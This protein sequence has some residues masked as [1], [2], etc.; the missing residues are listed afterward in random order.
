MLELVIENTSIP[1]DDSASI[2]ITAI[3][4]ALSTDNTGKVYSL[5]FKLPWS[6]QLLNLLK[7]T[8]RF[9]AATKPQSLRAY[10]KVAGFFLTKGVMKSND[11][12]NKST[13]LS[14]D[15]HFKKDNNA[16]LSKLTDFKISEVCPKI[17]IPQTVFAGYK[18]K[19]KNAAT[20]GAYYFISVNNT[21]FSYTQ[22]SN[23]AIEAMTHF[24]DAINAVY[25]AAASVFNNV[26]AGYLELIITCTASF[27]PIMD[28]PGVIESG[29]FE[30]VHHSNYANAVLENFKLFFLENILNPRTDISFNWVINE[31]FYQG[32]NPKFFFPWFN[33]AFKYDGDPDW[34]IPH[35][36]PSVTEEFERSFIPFYRLS[37]VFDRILNRIGIDSMAFEGNQDIWSDLMTLIID[38]HTALDNVRKDYFFTAN[39]SQGVE[40]FLN[41]H[42]AEI[43]SAEHLPDVSAKAFLDAFAESFNLEYDVTDANILLF[44]KKNRIFSQPTVVWD[45]F[46][47]DYKRGFKDKNG[48][49][50]RYLK[51]EQELYSDATLQPYK[52]G[53][54]SDIIE[55]PFAPVH[56]DTGFNIVKSRRFGSTSAFNFGKKTFPLRFFF[57]IGKVQGRYYGSDHTTDNI[58]LAFEGEK[59][60]YEILWKGSAELKN[61][62]FPV[63]IERMIAPQ[64]LHHILS[65]KNSKVF[66]ITENGH[67]RA[68]IQEVS[69][70]IARNS[71][72][73]LRVRFE[74][75]IG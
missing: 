38:N 45:T 55:M 6:P 13:A 36:N 61:T 14:F 15:V 57:D 41:C 42:V 8:R 9:D 46:I 22:N 72:K 12:N 4:P 75:I 35:N 40:R 21:Q 58:S 43:L 29:G 23:Q 18:I 74:L 19:L 70:K 73:L 60:M 1:M 68:F 28:K 34:T 59:G 3:N 44:K 64:E 30:Y 48:F 27:S 2:N 50:L 37:Y 17:V 16:I 63:S 67:V 65:F 47:E 54:G 69:T 25:P 53:E 33:Y 26:S 66:L 5:P 52:V 49:T 62:G 11:S 7:H 24:R 56:V 10:I 20:P 32:K 51:V 71:P 31:E 39:D